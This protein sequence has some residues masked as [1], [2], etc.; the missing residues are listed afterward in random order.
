MCASVFVSVYLCLCAFAVAWGRKC[1]HLSI[2]TFSFI[3]RWLQKAGTAWLGRAFFARQ[4][5]SRRRRMRT[6]K[7][8]A[9]AEAS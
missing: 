7:E 1:Q 3:S 5:R 9:A 2:R 6:L 8:V 4:E